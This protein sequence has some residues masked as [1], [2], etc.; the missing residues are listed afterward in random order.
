MAA[1]CA[2]RHIHGSGASRRFHV[3]GSIYVFSFLCLF[4][5]V[6]PSVLCLFFLVVGAKDRTFATMGL[7][8]HGTLAPE[9]QVQ[10]DWGAGSPP[11]NV[12]Y[13]KC[14]VFESYL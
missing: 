6:Y 13:D 12:E 14:Y 9:R 5:I 2:R 11:G 10:G 7:A 8:W 1:R 3:C 4:F